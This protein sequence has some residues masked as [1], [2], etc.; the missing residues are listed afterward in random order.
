MLHFVKI[1]TFC[2]IER[3]FAQDTK[4]QF[5]H[6]QL[7]RFAH[8]QLLHGKLLCLPQYA[9]YP[10]MDCL[11]ILHSGKRRLNSIVSYAPT[12]PNENES[13]HTE[14]IIR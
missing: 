12:Q 8:F 1:R 11:Q 9:L 7:Y 5:A 3:K 13:T 10:I 6:N 14:C 2:T 4:L